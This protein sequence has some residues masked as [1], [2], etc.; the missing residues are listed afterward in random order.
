MNTLQQT[1]FDIKDDFEELIY[2]YNSSSLQLKL[3]L[4]EIK[5]QKDHIEEISFF[6]LLHQTEKLIKE[7]EQYIKTLQ[8]IIV[9]LTD[10]ANETELQKYITDK[11][12]F[13]N[14]YRIRLNTIA[15]LI[16]STDWQSPSYNHSIYSLAGKQ[17]G[18]I[19]GTF[20][21]YK[22]DQHLDGKQYEVK[23]IREFLK[24]VI[25]NSYYAFLTHTGMSALTTVLYYLNLYKGIKKYIL[26]GKNIYFENKEI[27][28]KMFLNV[29]EFE[30]CDTESIITLIQRHKPR[31]II[32]DS[33][34]NSYNV[35]RTDIRKLLNYLNKNIKE[36]IYI[37][38]DNTCLSITSQPLSMINSKKI[39][40]ICIES[41]NKYHQFGMD[42]VTAGIIY[43]KCDIKNYELLYNARDHSGSNI[44]DTSVYSLPIPNKK[45]LQKRLNRFE[46]N[47]QHIMTAVIEHL[48]TFPSTIISG[49]S[50]AK[51]N[52]ENDF[53]GSYF[54]FKF[55]DS[56]K[57]I[58]L[59]KK[60]ILLLI[61]EGKKN[62]VQI[63]AG[64]SFGLNTSR[65]YLTSLRS[66]YGDPFVRFSVGTETLWEVEKI[67]QVLIKVINRLE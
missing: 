41:L 13:T 46:R 45:I 12:V 63:V 23:F 2:L 53:L 65:I 49:I 28:Q 31:V 16:T 50:Y 61:D 22:R 1:L 25:N 59:Y 36:D 47:I 51:K 15:G 57:K 27:I 6:R 67:I 4:K 7:N 20:N 43:T 52:S 48:N 60:M 30:E 14:M 3:F 37:V 44:S 26:M 33:L 58:N 39:H 10:T 32:L 11:Y 38:I 24:G 64:T 35:V 9:S 54:T 55:H 5:Q 34:S 40:I 56:Y 29:D 17:T 42:R 62:N 21:D 66:D 18:K 19:K 8:N